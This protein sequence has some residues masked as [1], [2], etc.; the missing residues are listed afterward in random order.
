MEVE[1][2]EPQ[3]WQRVLEIKLPSSQIRDKLEKLYMKYRNSVRLNGFRRG[4]V[5]MSIIKTRFGATIMAEAKEETINE[6]CIRA[7]KENGI[8]PITQGKVTD[9]KWDE[10]EGLS[11]KA[12]FEIMPTIEAKNYKGMKLKVHSPK[13]KKEELDAALNNLREQNATY[14][15][16]VTRGAIEGDYIVTDYEVLGEKK[17]IVRK[18]RVQNYT[19]TLGDKNLPEEF[20]RALLGGRAGDVKKASIRYPL[21]YPNESLRDK[22][23]EYVFYVKEI[24][25]KRLP[26]LD[27]EFAKDMGVN[28]LKELKKNLEKEIEAQKRQQINRNLRAKV[29]DKLIEENPFEPPESLVNAYLE[30][31]M[32][33]VREREKLD[34]AAK[35][36]VRELALWRTK[37]DIL[38]S[39]VADKEK[40]NLSKAEL[41]KVKKENDFKGN[42]E[43]L[44]EIL[45]IEKALDIVIKNASIKEEVR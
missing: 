32:R 27:N 11:F 19:I 37:R 23:F 31:I 17:G 42:I 20:T 22:Y 38:L 26:P 33:S 16:T 5:P 8:K 4:K 15:T 10:E 7:L 9:V 18:E 24:K 35:E 45:R 41:E 44:K 30:D 14:V 34:D 29:V 6:A 40:L 13:V 2:K 28:S 1:I 36:K 3:E 39:K 12:S 43:D 25:E 21:D